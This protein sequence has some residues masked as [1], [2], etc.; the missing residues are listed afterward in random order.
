MHWDLA[1]D[2][3]G[4]WVA[5]GGEFLDLFRL[6]VLKGVLVFGLWITAHGDR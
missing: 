3:A 6:L 1:L 2:A 4:G 5:I